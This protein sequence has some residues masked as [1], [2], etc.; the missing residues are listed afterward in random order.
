MAFY[1]NLDPEL[2]PG[3][4]AF[5]G[6]GLTGGPIDLENLPAFRA[7][8]EELLRAQMEEMVRAQTAPSD[9]VSTEDRRVPGPDEDERNRDDP[10]P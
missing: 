7:H 5:K 8:L 4:D 2:A 1:T 10:P 6:M 3:L 9:Q